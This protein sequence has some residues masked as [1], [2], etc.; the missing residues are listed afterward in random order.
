MIPETDGTSVKYGFTTVET[1]AAG[2]ASLP[3]LRLVREID[4]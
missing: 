4:R 1:G 2:P 3:A